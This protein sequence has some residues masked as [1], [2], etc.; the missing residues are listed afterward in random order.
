LTVAERSSAFQKEVTGEP[1]WVARSP[2]ITDPFFFHGGIHPGKVS[3]GFG[4]AF[5]P[6]GGKE[7]A[8]RDYE[9]LMEAGLWNAGSK[10]QIPDGAVVRGREANGDPPFVVRAKLNAGLHPGKIQFAFGAAFIVWWQE[11][12]VN[13]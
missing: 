12:P 2:G 5:I 11:V 7:E 8:V 3:P 10:G 13:L 4:A 9:V 6:F 1:L